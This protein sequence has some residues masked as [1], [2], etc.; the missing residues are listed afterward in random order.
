MLQGTGTNLFGYS[1]SDPVN[2]MDRTGRDPLDDLSNFFQ[3]NPTTCKILVNVFTLACAYGCTGL[4]ALPPP[5][6]EIAFAACVAACFAG[7]AFGLPACEP[8]PPKPEPKT[9]ANSP[10]SAQGG[11]AGWA[12]SA[13]PAVIGPVAFAAVVLAD[14]ARWSSSAV[15]L[16]VEVLSF[17]VLRFARARFGGT[18][19]WKWFLLA[20]QWSCIASAAATSIRW[21]SLTVLLAHLGLLCAVAI[22]NM[23]AR[24][25][26]GEHR[27]AKRA[28]ILPSN[29]CRWLCLRGDGRAHRCE[30]GRV[31]GDV[32]G[33]HLVAPKS[34][35]GI[36]ASTRS[37][38]PHP[39][40][41]ESR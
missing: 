13:V 8:K 25:Q 32:W 23:L 15:G 34:R 12:L 29:T 1:L 4:L 16:T 7:G 18:A 31:C 33:R 21:G 10:S 39:A 22:T 41:L 11:G 37:D 5:K 20:W 9:R 26:Q 35:V 2:R 17:A 27:R 28:S 40:S 24:G 30:L 36:V 14:A 38:A 6:G 19:W 3:E